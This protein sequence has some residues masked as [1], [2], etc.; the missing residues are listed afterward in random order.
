MAD[1]IKEKFSPSQVPIHIE[2]ATECAIFAG[3]ATVGING[4]FP[5]QESS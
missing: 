1:T 5:W 2:P 3:R 4:Q